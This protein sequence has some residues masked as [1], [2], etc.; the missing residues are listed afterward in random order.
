MPPILHRSGN[1]LLIAL[2]LSLLNACGQLPTIGQPAG[3]KLQRDAEALEAAGDYQGAAQLYLTAAASAGIPQQYTLQMQ[4]ADILI[5]GNQ[6][7]QAHALLQPLQSAGLGGEL[8]DRLTFLRVRLALAEQHPDLA[9]ELLQQVPAGSQTTEY[10]RLR[11]EAFESNGQFH[12]AAQERV[13]LDPLLTGSDQRIVNQRA[14]WDDLN[15]LSDNELQQLRKAPPPDPLSGWLELVELTRLYLQQPDA[16]AE[17]IPHWQ[18]RY[19]AHPASQQ[20]LDELLETMRSAG[21]APE[22]VAVL[23]PLQGELAAAAGAVRD[24]I[25]AAYYDTPVT[26]KR[27][28]LHV[29]DS[30]SNTQDMLT[31]YQQAVSAGATFVIGPLRKEMVDALARQPSLPVP[32]LALNRTEDSATVP[33]GLYQFG[34]APEDEAREAAR[35]AWRNGLTRSVALLPDND[36]G[37][38]VFAAFAAEWKALGGTLL[39]SQRYDE[40]Q[41][42]HSDAITRLLH[43]DGSNARRQQL[44]RLLGMQLAFEPRRRQDV[45]FVFLVASPRQARLIRPQLSFYRASTL[46]VYAT[47]RVYTG[48]PDPARDIDLNG[49]VFCD[50][51]WT[52]EDSSNRTRL[53]QSII[54]SWPDNS[55]RYARLYAL[56]IDAYRLLPYLGQQQSN[57]FGSYHGVSG[58][59][60]LGQ[61]GEINRTLRCARFQNGVPVLL[62][63][64]TDPAGAAASP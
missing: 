63:Q 49:I 30:G 59:L 27:P 17:V 51:P 26:G 32:V 7:S 15:H 11:A 13:L 19:P 22:H 16:L 37:E 43:L 45:D 41:T 2:L 47:S 62:E 39:E 18:Q 58:N 25:I 48:D 29:Y 60:S 24:G 53:Q 20:F 40:T 55:I 44:Q 10:H 1:L 4:A 36:W 57:L 56:G 33:A 34:L 64:G 42:D 50:T 54:E 6:Y 35:L 23:L 5:R 9:L 61:H 31:S 14:T 28:T 21:Q 12:E 8:L 46:P 38:R 3:S 52:L